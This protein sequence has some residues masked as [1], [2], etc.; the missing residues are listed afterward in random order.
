MPDPDAAGGAYLSASALEESNLSWQTRMAL[1]H[2]QAAAQEHV[3]AVEAIVEEKAA[4]RAA[5]AAAVAA[6]EA[7]EKHANAEAYVRGHG[8]KSYL[9]KFGMWN[10][11]MRA[12]VA[13]R[14][15]RQDLVKRDEEAAQWREYQASTRPFSAPAKRS[16]GFAPFKQSPN[17]TPRPSSAH[18]QKPPPANSQLPGGDG[19]GG[20]SVTMK[21]VFGCG[22]RADAEEAAPPSQPSPTQPAGRSRTPRPNAG[23]SSRPSSARSSRPSS[24][25]STRFEPRK[26][27][28]PPRPASALSEPASPRSWS[29]R[30]SP[31]H[32][33]GP[34]C[35]GG[36]N[37]AVAG[38]FYCRPPSVLLAGAEGRRAGGS[39]PNTWEGEKHIQTAILARQAA[40]ASGGPRRLAVK[41]EYPYAKQVTA[42]TRRS[43]QLPYRPPPASPVGFV[44]LGSWQK[45]GG[46]E[47]AKALTASELTLTFCC[48][49]MFRKRFSASGDAAFA[50]GVRKVLRELLIDEGVGPAGRAAVEL[51]FPFGVPSD[52]WLMRQ[53]SSANPTLILDLTLRLRGARCLEEAMLKADQLSQLLGDT[54]GVDAVDCAVT[55][56]RE[57][58]GEYGTFLMN[59]AKEEEE[60]R[61]KREI[62]ARARPKL[63]ASV[64]GRDIDDALAKE[65]EE[66]LARGEPVKA[67]TY[68][69]M[70]KEEPLSRPAPVARA[71][72]AVP[73]CL[74]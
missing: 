50:R 29:G 15:R 10:G 6:A 61:A 63:Q 17:P 5:Q 46:R 31:R 60:E 21:D 19:A 49:G 44:P 13:E 11:A 12:Q 66:K 22:D 65:Q 3:A 56:Q 4:V 59:A 74:P 20:A 30:V 55:G 2:A 32:T 53:P 40:A 69:W 18:V 70:T 43:A 71:G 24:A 37:A 67:V 64:E 27:T 8:V 23:A 14:Q 72:A 42:V 9:Q 26:G 41:T 57:G 39:H 62:A 33:A 28:L 54:T 1:R 36:G 52:A 16:S 38:G 7:A 25:R 48:W 73:Q 45:D 51:S 58:P 68:R 47:A 35:S 34:A